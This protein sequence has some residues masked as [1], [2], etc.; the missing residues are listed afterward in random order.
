MGGS[1][2]CGGSER[3]GRIARVGHEV[4][5][6]ECPS[7]R[8][9]RQAVGNVVVVTFLG[10]ED[11]LLQVRRSGGVERTHGDADPVPRRWIKE[12]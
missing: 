7:T 4:P 6:I 11:V 10:H 5:P 12:Q 2:C 8:I 1:L 9:L 3:D